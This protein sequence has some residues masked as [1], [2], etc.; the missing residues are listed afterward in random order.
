LLTFFMPPRE[1]EVDDDP[2]KVNGVENYEEGG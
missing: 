2:K 1:I